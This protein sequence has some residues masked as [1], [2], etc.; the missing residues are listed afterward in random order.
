[1][2]ERDLAESEH[3][4]LEAWRDRPFKFRVKET[5]AGVWEYWL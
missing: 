4:T 1:M 3:I 5:L 2:F